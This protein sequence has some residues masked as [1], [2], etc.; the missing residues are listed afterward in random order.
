MPYRL[1][2]QELLEAI[3]IRARQQNK[4]TGFTIGNTSKIDHHGLYFTPLRTTTLMVSAGVVVYSEEQ[5]IEVAKIVDGR[6]DYVLVDAEKKIPNERDPLELANV[7]RCVREYIRRSTLWVYKGNDLSVDAVDGLLAQLTKKDTRGL[8]GKKITIL[9]AGNVGFKL[10]LRLV[11]RGAH[12]TITRR[13]KEILDHLVQAI[14]FVKPVYTQASVTGVT[15]NVAAARGAEI[16]IGA[17]GGV[18]MI[19]AAMIEDLAPFAMIIDVGKGVL[20]PQAVAAA[21]K[22]RI[23]VYRLDIS[24]AFE[25]LVHH[26]RAVENLVEKKSGRTKFHD[27][28]IIS[29]GLLGDKEEIVVDNV[30][31]PKAVYGI[32]DG[33][34]DFIRKL[35]EEQQ[36]R[37]AKIQKL[38]NSG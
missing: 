36:M 20:F 25:G 12:V 16:L 7:E 17:S 9:G 37:L 1:K 19:T 32:A 27:E 33:Q 18:A 15:D 35:T 30:W 24:A 11:E 22:R 13:N 34:G 14:N 38:I 29:G 3:N 31:A 21:R 23:S 28:S 10:A 5:A 8:G 26:L 6:V 4:L 2:T